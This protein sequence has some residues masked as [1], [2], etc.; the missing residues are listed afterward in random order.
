MIRSPSQILTG[1]QREPA[2]AVELRAGEVSAVLD[3][4]DLRG[5][6]LHGRELA[7]RIYVAVRDEVWGT[8]PGVIGDLRVEQDADSFEIAFTS[9]HRQG[10]IDFEW[11]ALFSGDADGTI[12]CS[13]DGVANSAFR[14]AKIGFNVHH[15]LLESVGRRFRAATLD[16]ELE[17]RIERQIEPQRVVDGTLTAMFA[18]YSE[19]AIEYG[20]GQEV[21]FSFA[22]DLFELQDHRNWSDGNFKSYGTPLSVPWPMDAEPGQRFRQRVLVRP[23]GVVGTPGGA[24]PVELR[25][26]APAATRL[27]LLGLGRAPGDPLD[28]HEAAL[29]SLA[30]PRHLRVAVRLHEPGWAD[31]LAAGLADCARLAAELELAVSLEE[32][33]DEQLARL[34]AALDAADIEVARVLVLERQDAFAAAAPITEPASLARARAALAAVVGDVPFAGGSDQFFSDVNRKPPAAEGLD[35]VCFGLC[36]QVHAADDASLMENLPSLADAIATTRVICPGAG[37]VVSPVTLASRLGPYP[38]GEPGPGDPPADVD[39]RGHA[40]FGAS[41]TLGAVSWLAREH[42]DSVTLYETSGPHGIVERVHDAPIVGVPSS[43]G[44]AYPVLHVLGDIAERRDDELIEIES[45]DPLAVSALAL[46]GEHGLR[47]LVANHGPLPR[48]IRIDGLASDGVRVRMLDETSAELAMDDPRG[49]RATV[50][51][52]HE[53]SGGGLALQLGPYAVARIDGSC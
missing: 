28:E 1:R 49:F 31:E 20:D 17:G 9:R 46:R 4:P 43:P 8:V 53:T 51:V 15:P 44:S 42:P 38:A 39:L 40:L 27:P 30:R 45:S 33:D 12:S 18:P 7:Q 10:P 50:E 34:A 6:R 14:Y 48:A 13:M 26:G 41:W 19:L 24:G 25:L 21:V 35:A 3:G 36:P 22:G 47:V 29:I 32:G 16:G 23:V 37:V 52:S 11:K 2:V 5:L